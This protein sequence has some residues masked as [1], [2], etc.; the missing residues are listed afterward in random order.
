MTQQNWGAPRPQDRYFPQ[1]YL[2]QQQS[3]P[4]YP[5]SFS[6]PSGYD[7]WRAPY[8]PL[9]RRHPFRTLLLAAIMVFVA[10]GFLSTLASFL[11]DVGAQTEDGPWTAPDGYP[12]APV[13]TDPQT[14]VPA[15]DR[16]P[17]DLPV[18]ATYSEA[19]MWL[20]DNAVYDQSVAVPTDCAVPQ[21]NPQTASTSALQKHLNELTA[22]LWQVWDPP[23]TQAGFVLPRPPVTVY[24]SPITTGCGKVDEV[25]ADY[26]AGDQRI[27]YAKQLYE[28][29]PDSLRSKPFMADTIIAHEFGHTVQARTGILVS[30]SAWEQKSGTPKSKQTE[31]SRRTEMQADCLAGMFVA[32]VAQANGL[33]AADRRDLGTL[34][35]SFGDDAMT[36]QSGVAYDHG[37]GAAR[38]QWF[39]A[40]Q[41]SPAIDACNTFT[42]PSSAV[43]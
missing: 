10:G 16:D 4:V 1:G 19:T 2:G 21:V 13:S 25:N 15:P 32:S 28:I 41:K 39:T 11:S 40:G 3:Y 36:G 20:E 38:Q 14:G 42:A 31:F 30:E 8:R 26:C 12:S 43:R 7:P 22:C 33:T 29:L 6:A 34:I 27:Y 18:P 37:S 35:Y 17:S 5:Q 23:V 24:T 9:R